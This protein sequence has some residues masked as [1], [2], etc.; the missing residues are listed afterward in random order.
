MHSTLRAFVEDGILRPTGATMTKQLKI[1]I[2]KCLLGENVRFDGGHKL[3]RYLRDV[4]GQYVRFVPVCPEVECGLPI[5]REALRL[6]GDPEAPRLVTSKTGRDYT[7]Q[8][9]TW[10]ATRL[11]EL[12]EDKLCGY[13]FKYGS[14]SSGMSR[15][16]VYPEQGGPPSM[17]GRGMFAAMFMDRFPLLP[18]E[19][20]GR[21]ND[22][23]LRENFIMRIFTVHRWQTML[24]NGLTPKALVDFH[25]RHK[26]LVMAHNVQAY[27]DLGKLVALAGSEELPSLARDYYQRL[28]NGLRKPATPKGHRNALDHCQGYF[29][30]EL[31]PFEK[32]ELREVIQQFAEGLIPRIVPVT[33]LNHY[34]RKYGQEYL[35][36]QVYLNPPPSE[37][38]LLNHL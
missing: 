12:A 37:L 21:L 28:L 29:K 27:R 35:A 8:M 26:I 20:D 34:I 31:E 36:S 15:V 2:A 9:Q 30:K 13:I 1:G 6:V 23:G 3:D 22:P 14:P 38:K 16:K 25:T 4:L 19:D 10:A 11:D 32:Q 24:Q 7:D 5:P 17:K 33:L 18:V